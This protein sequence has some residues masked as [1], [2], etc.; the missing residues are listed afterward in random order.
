ML[1]QLNYRPKVATAINRE[2]AQGLQVPPGKDTLLDW[3]LINGFRQIS[4]RQMS[5][6]GSLGVKSRN[7]NACKP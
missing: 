1:Y 7:R 3:N 6:L 2:Q 4:Y 5:T